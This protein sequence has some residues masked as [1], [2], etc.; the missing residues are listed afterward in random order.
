[1]DHPLNELLSIAERSYVR[2][3][4]EQL[5]DD[6]LHHGDVSSFNSLLEELVL[7]GTSSL[8]VLREILHV[9]RAMKSDA[10]QQGIDIRQD[11]QEAL[12]EFGIESPEIMERDLSGPGRPWHTDRMEQ[13]LQAW[14][15]HLCAEDAYLIAEIWHEAGRRVEEVANNV[16]MLRRLESC[17]L[18][19]ID[20]LAYE[21][22]HELDRA[23]RKG[24]QLLH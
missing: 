16:M 10:G 6:C 24:E 13:V 5:I 17:V 4:A 18:D 23:W 9:I 15:A 11:L 3:E 19:W 20:G 8:D 1:M 21:S 2:G 22:V 12:I 14:T 7:A